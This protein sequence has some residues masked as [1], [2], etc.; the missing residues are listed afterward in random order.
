MT[1][2]RAS[3][4]VR[5]RVSGLPAE[6]RRNRLLLMLQAYFDGSGSSGD[7]P[8]YVLAGYLARAEDWEKFSDEWQAILDQ[9]P[10]LAYFKMMEARGSLDR[11]SQFF[12]WSDAEI[13][14]RLKQFIKCINKHALCGVISAVPFEP[15]QRLFKGKYNPK[16][17]DR[18]YFLS[19]FGIMARIVNFAARNNLKGK[20][21]FI[22]DEEGGENA[23]FLQDQFD[24]FKSFA[25]PHLA[26][27]CGNR[28]S[29]GK[30]HELNPLQAADLIAWH[31]R[32]Y[33]YDVAKNLDPTAQPYHAYFA[34]LC[35][36]DHIVDNWTEERL[37]EASKALNRTVFQ[38][39]LLGTKG[40]TMTWPDPS[41]SWR[42]PYG[43]GLS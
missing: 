4:Y 29:F 22:F 38:Q 35:N 40:L 7:S 19:F 16:V 9:E 30:D 36:T 26:D 17:L 37:L 39:Q 13:D 15:Y 8:V 25:P 1:P 41:I 23:G 21:D 43:E 18:P 31:A 34:N 5:A 12:G 3:S 33:H 28:P 32:R 24:V 27:L 6:A 42:L 14:A 10:R 11:K 20:V 2:E